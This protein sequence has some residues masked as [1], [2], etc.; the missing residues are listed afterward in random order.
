LVTVQVVAV[1]AVGNPSYYCCIRAFKGS[2]T[3]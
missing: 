2:S 3:I 1:V